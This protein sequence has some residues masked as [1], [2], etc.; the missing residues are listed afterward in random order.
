MT[1]RFLFK[2]EAR[3]EFFEA[4]AWYEDKAPGLGRKFAREVLEALKSARAAPEHF[5]KVRGRARRIRLR[6]F[7]AYSIYFAI[8]DD[9][10]SVISIFHGARNPVELHRRLR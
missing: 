7:K 2:P 6:R 10:F 8:K 9:V 5:R 3:L 1:P 4:I